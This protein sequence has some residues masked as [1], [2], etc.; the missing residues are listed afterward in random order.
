[1]IVSFV[2]QKGGVGKSSLVLATAWELHA[3]GSRVLV[4]DADAQATARTAGEVAAEMG[5]SGPVTLA[6]G[7][8]LARQLPA[9]AKDFDHVVIDT[10]GR[11]AADTTL[12][13]LA[14]SDVA[15]V[16]IGP[17]P[18]EVWASA[19]T[20]AVVQSARESFRPELR[21]AIVFTRAERTVLS[22]RVRAMLERAELPLLEASLSS[23]VSWRESLLSGQ[24]VAQAA[25]DDP[26]ALEVVRF[27]SELLQFAQV[28]TPTE[29]HAHAV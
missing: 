11:M 17:S 12:A 20:I 24:G 23:R 5:H 21:G 6:F 3:R 29:T 4:A 10:P 13:A 18:G 19:A 22:R 28:E 2:S 16:P 8:D 15:I 26:A 14:V 1:M 7:R 27:V 9:V 25:P